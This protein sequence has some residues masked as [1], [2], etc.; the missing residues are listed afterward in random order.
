MIPTLTDGVVTLRA[1]R[2]DDV[3]GVFEQS[4]DP[5]SQRWTTIPVPYATSDAEFFIGELMPRGWADDSE[6]GFVIE[7]EGRYAGSASLRNEGNGRGEIGYGSHPWARGTGYVERGLRLLLEW[8]FEEKGLH[9]VIWW[10]HVGNWAS[11]RL[12]WKIGFTVEG[13]V[14]KWQ[15][16]R[17]ELRDAWVGTLLRDDPREPSSTWLDN[18]VVV[19]DGVRLRP[20]TEADVPRVAEGIGDADTQFWL[21]FFPRGFDE[22]DGRRY[23][24]QVTERLATNHTV[25]WAWCTEDDDL[26]LGAVGLHRI[27]GGEPEIGYWTHPDARGRRLTATAARL[28]V[29]HGFEVL[30]LPRLSGFAA[31]G[32]SASW[33][34]L[35]R[36]GMR[37]IGVQREATHTGDGAPADLVGYDL[38]RAEWADQRSTPT[39]STDS[40]APT[41]AGD[42]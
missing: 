15:P 1:H 2:P 41:S 12:A 22:E 24:E 11:R 33:K 30:E 6:W 26:L 39:P 29:D 31:T 34:V 20:F 38:L 42:R 21:S 35:E 5:D 14:R 7:A 17:G 23:V 19:G 18:P 28:A 8:G 40:A 27:S 25:T 10:A 16:Q 3:T 9:T 4:Q 32:N 37:R 36:L 13:T